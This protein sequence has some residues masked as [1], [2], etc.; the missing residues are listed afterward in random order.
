MK[1]SSKMKSIIWK[2]TAPLF[3]SLLVIGFLFLFIMKQSNITGDYLDLWVN[4]SLI[5]ISATFLITGF[6]ILVITSMGIIFL[7]QLNQKAPKLLNEIYKNITG[8]AQVITSI[9]HA[10]I[11]PIL[12]LESF[13]REPKEMEEKKDI[14]IK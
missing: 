11:K 1:N 4:I 2:I 6:F 13:S 9:A 7:S 12:L 8:I 3:I 5:F 10:V 14:E